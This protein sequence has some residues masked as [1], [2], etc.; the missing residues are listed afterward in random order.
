MRFQATAVRS[1]SY[2]VVWLAGIEFGTCITALLLDGIFLPIAW[3]C[4]CAVTAVALATIGSATVMARAAQ[5]TA[6]T[7]KEGPEQG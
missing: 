3:F 4:V 5:P 1:I 7:A 6:P 2:F